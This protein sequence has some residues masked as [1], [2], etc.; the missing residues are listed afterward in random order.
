MDSIESKKKCVEKSKLC[1]KAK[2]AFNKINSII[3]N[4]VIC[5]LKQVKNEVVCGFIC[6]FCYNTVCHWR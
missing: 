1:I 6:H 4:S 5:Y 2:F 3:S